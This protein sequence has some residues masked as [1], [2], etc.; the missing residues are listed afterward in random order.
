[1]VVRRLFSQG[2]EQRTEVGPVVFFWEP[3]LLTSS[4]GAAQFHCGRIGGE[5]SACC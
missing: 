2:A 4:Q 1:M 3:V 5:T